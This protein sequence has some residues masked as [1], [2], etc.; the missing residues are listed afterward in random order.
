MRASIASF[1][2]VLLRLAAPGAGR[3]L[4]EPGFAVHVGGA[5]A[6]VACALAQFG[7][8]ARMLGVV[9]DNAL[10]EAALA[11][12]RRMGVDTRDVRRASG[13][14]GLY[15]F[16][17]G[18]MRRASEVLYDRADSA[19][20]RHVD[21]ETDWDA[22]LVGVDRL[23]LSGVTPA[24]G[25]GPARAAQ[26]AAEQAVGL[27][28]PVS[29]DGNFRGKLWQ[30]WGGD[31]AQHLRP[32]M[33]QADVLFADHRDLSLVLGEDFARHSGDAADDEAAAA[34]FA[35]FPRLRWIAST[36]RRVSG[37]RQQLLAARM[38]SADGCRWVSGAV[39]L[40]GIVDRIGAGDAFAAGFLHA[41]HEDFEPQDRLDFALACGA[42]KHTIPGDFL[43]ASVADIRAWIAA[44]SAD[45]RR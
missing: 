13:R 44:G 3:L 19:F 30:V 15:F 12:L 31:P 8:P 16:E 14:M 27:G 35:A 6:N 17:A 2:E 4:Q 36:T 7:H 22:L 38:R 21:A 20:A 41:L 29:F 10:G 11:E 26:V 43:R 33:A 34:A 32:L 23:H 37:A 9:S 39:A 1:G 18:A 28:I 24:L 5:E 45:V 42:C 40:D 25:A